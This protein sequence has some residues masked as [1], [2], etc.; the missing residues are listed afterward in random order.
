MPVLVRTAILALLAG[1]TVGKG[2]GAVV[3]S[4]QIEGCEKNTDFDEQQ[5]DLDADFFVGQ[6]FLDPDADQSMRRDSLWIR[7]QRGGAYQESADALSIQVVDLANVREGEVEDVMA[8]GCQR[9]SG[10]DSSGDVSGCV[11]AELSL[12]LSCP[13]AFENLVATADLDADG[14]PIPCP[15]S[16]A[17]NVFDGDFDD[18]AAFEDP[19]FAGDASVPG[20]LHPSCIVFQTLGSDYGDE[21]AAAFHFGVHDARM[22]DG[23][24]GAGGYLRGRFRFELQ[25]GAGAQAFP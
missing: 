4:I 20:A 15:T 12:A 11:R 17:D 18:P 24:S 2:T 1:C 5:F 9:S 22:L 16:V 8:D 10:E 19:F 7:I 21:I 14:A 3:G 25:R 23:P 6:P 13:D